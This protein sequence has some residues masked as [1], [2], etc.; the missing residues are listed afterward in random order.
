M[1]LQAWDAMEEV[2]PLRLH[3]EIVLYIQTLSYIVA[4]FERGSR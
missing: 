2:E 1:Y 4:L 3:S